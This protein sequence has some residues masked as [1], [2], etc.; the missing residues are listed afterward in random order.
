MIGEVRSDGNDSGVSWYEGKE[1]VHSLHVEC[2]LHYDST[3]NNIFVSG[4]IKKA[5]Q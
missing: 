5:L 2:E 3:F 1:L 4:K